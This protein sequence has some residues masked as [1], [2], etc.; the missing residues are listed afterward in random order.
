M[1]RP[2]ESHGAFQWTK[3]Q[4][5]LL[6]TDNWDDIARLLLIGPAAS[7]VPAPHTSHFPVTEADGSPRVPKVLTIAGSDSGGGAGIQASLRSSWN[8]AGLA[9]LPWSIQKP[10]HYIFIYDMKEKGGPKCLRGIANKDHL[11]LPAH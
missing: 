9:L 1:N 5:T 8:Q 10:V 11:S 3:G 4:G 6:T 2:G 7:A